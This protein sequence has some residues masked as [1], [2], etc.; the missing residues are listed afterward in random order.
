[1][2]NIE[3]RP[4]KVIGYPDTKF[5]LFPKEK[6]SVAFYSRVILNTGKALST[7]F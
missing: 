3:T 4:N 5:K 6:Q 1:M 2:I 7:T